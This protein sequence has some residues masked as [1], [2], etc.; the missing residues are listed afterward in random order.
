MQ[1]K[2][3]T[4][5]LVGSL[6]GIAL[7]P[8]GFAQDNGPRG[9]GRQAGDPPGDEMRGARGGMGRGMRSE[10]PARMLANLD[11]DGDG[12]ISADEF[13]DE[14]VRQTER[15][16]ERLDNDGDG[17][18]GA[19]ESAR[20][21]RPG[22]DGRQ[23][24]RERPPIDP[25]LAE[26]CRPADGDDTL[27]AGRGRRGD[28]ETLAANAD[29]DGDGNLNLAELSAAAASLAEDRFALL[30]AD[31][32]GYATEAELSAAAATA[33]TRLQEMRECMRA[34]AGAAN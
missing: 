9:E 7:L 8:A 10:G 17:L 29:S 22:R 19:D 15:L 5:L 3:L 27:A 1:M 33:R 24:R 25:A 11:S 32:D 26:S 20:P 34:A 2:T 13:I 30:D 6:I 16:F 28:R 18:L 12:R 23:A 14:R 4:A 31:G 21:E